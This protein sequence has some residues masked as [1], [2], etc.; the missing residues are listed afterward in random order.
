[1][2]GKIHAMSNVAMTWQETTELAGRL[3]RTPR[4]WDNDFG[5]GT[6]SGAYRA[7]DHYCR[8]EPA[9]LSCVRDSKSEAS[10]RSCS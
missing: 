8:A 4:G 5:V 3:N 1:M 2:I 7:L 10:C 9:S 6:D